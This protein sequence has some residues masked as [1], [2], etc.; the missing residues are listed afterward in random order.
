MQNKI[1]IF[2]LTSLKNP[3]VK[4]ESVEHFLYTQEDRQITKSEKE[5][6]A[7]TDYYKKYI[8]SNAFIFNI[9]H[10]N[11]LYK[12][13]CYTQELHDIGLKSYFLEHEKKGIWKYTELFSTEIDPVV[14]TALRKAEKYYRITVSKLM[15]NK[16]KQTGVSGSSFANNL[17]KEESKVKNDHNN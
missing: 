12:I 10:N 6:L 2:K 5:I 13:Q 8:D 14:A 16:S 9:M 1:F 4:W 15:K 3:E 17:R 11:E 7:K